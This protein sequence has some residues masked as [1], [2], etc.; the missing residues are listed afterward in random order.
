MEREGRAEKSPPTDG[1]SSTPPQ[2]GSPYWTVKYAS[3]AELPKLLIT[4]L[5]TV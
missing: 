2:A 5:M 4:L 3:R 1:F